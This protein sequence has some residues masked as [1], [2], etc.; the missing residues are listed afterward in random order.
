MKRIK[1]RIPSICA[2]VLMVGCLC[3]TTAFAVAPAALPSA[4]E[5]IIVEQIPAKYDGNNEVVVLSEVITSTDGTTTETT[6]PTEEQTDPVETANE[7]S[8]G[9]FDWYVGLFSNNAFVI[10]FVAV[11]AVVALVL[12]KMKSGGS[13]KKGKSK[14]GGKSNRKD[15]L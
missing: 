1:S 4:G 14:G 9:F 13:R 7:E 6:T 2:A 15:G 3:A 8:G 5:S 10:A 11:I 12:M